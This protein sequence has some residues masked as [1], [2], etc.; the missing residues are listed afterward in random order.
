MHRE[1]NAGQHRN[2]TAANKFR[3]CVIN[4]IYLATALTDQIA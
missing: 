2:L 3:E 1:Q 4:V